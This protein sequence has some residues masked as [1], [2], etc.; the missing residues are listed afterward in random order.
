MTDNRFVQV[1]GS[2]LFNGQTDYH[3]TLKRKKNPIVLG[4]HT[5]YITPKMTLECASSVEEQI[6][7]FHD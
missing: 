1:K 2:Y 7:T 3:K 5:W 6:Q 4:L